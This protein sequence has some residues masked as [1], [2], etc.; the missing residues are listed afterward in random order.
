MVTRAQEKEFPFLYLRDDKDAIYSKFGANKTPHVFVLDSE[1]TVQYIGAIDDN[2]QDADNVSEHFVANAIA[3]LE[4]G[5]SPNP[6]TTKAVGCPIKADGGGHAGGGERRG[7]PSPEKILE[8]M[9]ANN[10]GVVTKAEA[11]GPLARDFERLD[12]D[13]DGQLTMAELKNISGPRG[14]K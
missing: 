14:P 8:D 4:K 5:E 1:L 2:A 11:K 13:E 6:A 9:D 3:A 10:D 7:P 12:A